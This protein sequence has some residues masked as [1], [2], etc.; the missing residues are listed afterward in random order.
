MRASVESPGSYLPG[1]RPQ[2]RGPAVAWP[3]V[4]SGRAVSVGSD[5]RGCLEEREGGS[6]AGGAEASSKLTALVIVQLVTVF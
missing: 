5:L 1:G 2:L 3:V 6:R 4:A